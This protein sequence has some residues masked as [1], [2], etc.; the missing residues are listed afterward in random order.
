M[1]KTTSLFLTCFLLK[2]IDSLIVSAYFNF[3][4]G[5]SLKVNVRLKETNMDYMRGVS[6]AETSSPAPVAS[7]FVATLKKDSLS[8]MASPKKSSLYT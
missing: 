5:I 7:G 6:V 2:N 1:V 3:I 8:I 4:Y